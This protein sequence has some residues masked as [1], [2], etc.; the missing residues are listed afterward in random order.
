MSGYLVSVDQTGPVFV[1][2]LVGE[3]DWD[4]KTLLDNAIAEFTASAADRA[5]VD[6]TGVTYLDSTGI[7]TLAR[8]AGQVAARGGRVVLLGVPGPVRRILQITELLSL[9][10]FAPELRLQ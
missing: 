1:M 7:A 8:L 10:D 4:S 3:I 5:Q 6:L 9:F 2:T